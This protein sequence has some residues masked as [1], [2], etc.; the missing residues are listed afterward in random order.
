[1]A[2]DQPGDNEGTSVRAAAEALVAEGHVAWTEPH[3]DDDFTAGQV[4]AVT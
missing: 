3:A 4:Q 1:V 2:R